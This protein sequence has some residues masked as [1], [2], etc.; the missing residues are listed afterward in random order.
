V[1][2]VWLIIGSVATP[3]PPNLCEPL[4]LTD[5]DDRRMKKLPDSVFLLA[6]HQKS[7]AI[8]A[9]AI[10]PMTTPRTMPSL[11]SFS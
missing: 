10:E 8:M 9:M 6:R 3:H 2:F 11:L 1:L 7:I 5:G 4:E